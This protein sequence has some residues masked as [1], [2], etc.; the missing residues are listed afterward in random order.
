MSALAAR[1]V[2]LMLKDKKFTH[3]LSAAKGKL[4][5]F[6]KGAAVA[7]AAV[8][9]AGVAAAGV[10]LRNFL[11][12]GDSL[13]KMSDRTGL[14]VES[15]SELRHAASQSGT[16]IGQVEKAL[17]Y[18]TQKG[19][20]PKNFDSIA[21][22]IDAIKDPTE[23][24]RAA[25][26]VWGM[27]A[28][29]ALLPMLKDLPALRQEARDLGF[30]M[31]GEAA[32]SAVRVGDMFANLWETLKMGTVA[33]GQA[34]APFLEVALPAIQAFATL[35]LKAMQDWAAWVASN[36]STVAEFIGNVWG[37]TMEWF[38]SLTTGVL[39][40]VIFV[41]DNWQNLLKM[42]L[43]SGELAIVRF[44]NQTIYFFSEALPGYLSWFADNWWDVF[45]DIGNITATVATNIWKNLK[46]LWDGIVGL[47][48]GE[49]FS[50]E[51][52]PLTQGFESAI[53]ELPKIAEREMGPLETSLQ[54]Q[55]DQ[56]AGQVNE[57]WDKAAT[58]GKKL[59]EALIGTGDPV[60]E[61]IAAQKSATKDGAEQIA[62]AAPL[63]NQGKQ[64]VL[65]SF[66]AAA[67]AAAGGN[68]TTDQVKGLRD[69]AKKQHQQLI[70]TIETAGGLA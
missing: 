6:A 25:M 1:F 58:E 8:A 43:V 30:V 12:L 7:G 69:D 26:E 62:G 64:Q 38:R 28:G 59:S 60:A 16:D 49:G 63:A 31:S 68:S 55:L 17:R 15:L 18:M 2:E 5:G 70:R 54:Q 52:T 29:P 45:K 10:G 4:I 67:L 57:G 22:S 20:D 33:I 56:I 32:Q 35:G 46:S 14:S 47:F 34:I 3:G 42:A 53:K 24:A 11:T 39:S 65:G 9:A 27:R 51:W 66:S 50:F 36:V 48:S 13:Q 21:A 19:L 44:A 23:K 40:G 61:L 41:W 37:T